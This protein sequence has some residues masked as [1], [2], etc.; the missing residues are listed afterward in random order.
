MSKN[1]NDECVWFDGKKINEKSFCSEFISENHLINCEGV[2]YDLNGIVDDRIIEKLIMEKLI[3]AGVCFGLSNKVKNLTNAMRILSAIEVFEFDNDC[4]HF[5]N[6]TYN[7][8][9][10]MFT[11][12]MKNCRNRLNICYNGNA[13]EPQHWKAFLNEMLTPEDILTLQEYLGYLLVNTTKAQ[14]MMFLVGKGGE[15]KS[16]IGVILELIFGKA[17]CFDSITALSRDKFRRGNL[18]GKTVLIDDDM[19]F[20][21]IRDTSFLKSLVTAETSISVEKKNQQAIQVKLCARGIVFSNGNP[22]SLYDKT[23]GWHRRL[24]VLNTKPVPKDR[25]PDRYLSEKLSAEAEGI[26]MWMLEGLKR[27]ISNSYMFTISEHT[28]EAIA[29][30]KREECNIMEFMQDVQAVQLLP[31][32]V[33]CS[34]DIYNAY[35]DW[36]YSNGLQPLKQKSFYDWLYNNSE[37]YSL[38]PTNKAYNGRNLVRGYVGIRVSYRS[39]IE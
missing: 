31:E 22:T 9:T 26:V 20:D 14:A 23:D 34:V 39:R 32:S 16:R 7:I 25:I 27:L 13:A 11:A 18:V 4:I 38:K 35:C 12:E 15:G 10:G 19:S 24:I 2:Y 6:G 5:Q 29:A 21:A 37:K 36:C 3:N 28:Q 17:C 33:T 8:N 30:L 1:I